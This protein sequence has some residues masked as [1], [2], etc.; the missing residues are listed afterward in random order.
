MLREKYRRL[1]ESKPYG[2]VMSVVD[3]MIG[4]E[5]PRDTGKWKRFNQLIDNTRKY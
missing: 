3:M 5:Q 2:V 4:Q 1:K